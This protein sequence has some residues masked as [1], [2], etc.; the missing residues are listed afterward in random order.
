MWKPLK[1]G[2]KN[3]IYYVYVLH[4]KKKKKKAVT[5]YQCTLA[6]EDCLSEPLLNCLMTQN[7]RIKILVFFPTGKYFAIAKCDLTFEICQLM[8]LSRKVKFLS[9]LS[10]SYLSGAILTFL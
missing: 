8:A 9:M 2:N 10:L 4:Q 7:I 1:W 6:D 5:S 3:Q